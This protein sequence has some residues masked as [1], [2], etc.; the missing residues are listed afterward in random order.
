MLK[1]ATLHFLST[2]ESPCSNTCTL[3]HVW[4][5]I[6]CV[7]LWKR[8][9]AAKLLFWPIHFQW[10][11]MHPFS[12][13][14]SHTFSTPQWVKKGC[15]GNEWLINFCTGL[16]KK[17]SLWVSLKVYILRKI[18]QK[19]RNILFL[20]LMNTFHKFC[21]KTGWVTTAL[22][23]IFKTRNVNDVFRVYSLV[24]LT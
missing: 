19:L 1:G 13:L 9:E 6:D 17:F 23:P 21:L 8:S 14:S 7:N 2:C 18:V 24:F 15:I 11:L 4:N 22:M 16:S 20:H 12:T 10:F 3:Y 5:L